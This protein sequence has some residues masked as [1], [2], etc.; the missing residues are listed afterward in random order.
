MN[1]STKH[2]VIWLLFNVYVGQ[3]RQ[4][5][6]F[7]GLWF[8]LSNSI[9]DGSSGSTAISST[10]ADFNSRS[11]VAPD[12]LGRRSVNTFEKLLYNERNNAC[13]CQQPSLQ[14]KYHEKKVHAIQIMWVN[15][16][17]QP[18]TQTVAVEQARKDPSR[19]GFYKSN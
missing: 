15:S 16:P 3:D 11:V 18:K 13:M 2:E 8:S 6:L 17:L 7:W 5:N 1:T 12:P 19:N 4:G 10:C 14:A 9:V